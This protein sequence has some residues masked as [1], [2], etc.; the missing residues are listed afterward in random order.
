MTKVIIV[1]LC[2]LLFTLAW[3]ESPCERVDGSLCS[4]TKE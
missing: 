2:A 1:V 3:T 4:S